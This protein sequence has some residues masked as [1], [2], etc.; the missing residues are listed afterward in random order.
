M[1]ALVEETFQGGRFGSL[2]GPAAAS[3]M[4]NSGFASP[5]QVTR[6][7]GPEANVVQNN[8]KGALAQGAEALTYLQGQG[9]VSA[10][11]A[12]RHIGTPAA[13]HTLGADIHKDNQARGGKNPAALAQ[14]PDVR[15]AVGSLVKGLA[16]GT[17]TQN[18]TSSRGPDKGRGGI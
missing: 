15:A 9:V 6:M 18:V 3:F 10:A 12:A 14:S 5:D 13:K 2:S 1:V 4:K 11:Q 17:H 16:G 7:S 8:G